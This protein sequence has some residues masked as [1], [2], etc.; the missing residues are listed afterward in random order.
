MR[1]AH[2]RSTTAAIRSASTSDPPNRSRIQPFQTSRSNDDT[3]RTRSIY[4][5]LVTG[6]MS[7]EEGR[8][9]LVQRNSTSE[10]METT[11][12]RAAQAEG[13]IVGVQDGRSTSVPHSLG[14]GQCRHGLPNVSAVDPRPR[15]LTD[16][17]VLQRAM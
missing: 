3:A 9:D 4:S 10:Y 13:S 8:R 16:I 1:C 17:A 14:L 6:S 15:H 12:H 7:D 5:G 11:R 2:L